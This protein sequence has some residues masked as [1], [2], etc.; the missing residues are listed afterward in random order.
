MLG[1]HWS[2]G[3]SK[4]LHRH[5]I[6]AAASLLKALLAI[7]PVAASLAAQMP[8]EVGPGYDIEM[9]RMAP[10]RDGTELEVWISK[11]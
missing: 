7:A 10:T 1:R 2:A 5:A 8:G 6:T 11:P 4:S 9:S 3:V